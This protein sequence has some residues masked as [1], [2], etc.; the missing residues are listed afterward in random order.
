MNPP[1]KTPEMVNIAQSRAQGMEPFVEASQ[2]IVE[3]LGGRRG[4]SISGSSTCNWLVPKPRA[5]EA[6]C[7]LNEL[8][9]GSVKIPFT[10]HGWLELLAEYTPDGP[11]EKLAV[12]M[13]GN[14]GVAVGLFGP[15]SHREGPLELAVLL[16]QGSLAS[17]GI[18]RGL[19]R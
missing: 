4:L 1:A 11:C 13:G 14:Q 19:P 8:A 3:A 7:S 12:V 2:K 15:M 17:L 9:P 16:Q 18:L 10:F 6:L 5:L